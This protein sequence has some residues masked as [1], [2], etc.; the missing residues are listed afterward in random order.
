M[1]TP[2]RIATLN[3][4]TLHPKMRRRSAAHLLEILKIDIAVFQETHLSADMGE[5]SLYHYTFHHVGVDNRKNNR[6]VAIA[7]A[8]D[9]QFDEK[10]F[11]YISDRL[12]GMKLKF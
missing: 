9:R 6:G 2:L 12:M 3:V 10:E 4:D 1:T 11:H 8:N 5:F 7:F